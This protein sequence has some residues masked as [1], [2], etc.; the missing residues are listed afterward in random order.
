MK[1]T[2]IRGI[3]AFAVALLAPR[4]VRTTGLSNLGQLSDDSNAVGCDSWLAGEIYT[5]T[6]SSGY[7]LNSFQLEMTNASSTRSGFSVMLYKR[8]TKTTSPAQTGLT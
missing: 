2:V 1:N 4:I 3:I 8:V 6:N 5:G 7:W